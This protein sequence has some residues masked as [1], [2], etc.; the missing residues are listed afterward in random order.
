M[1]QT[2]DISNFSEL[3]TLERLHYEVQTRQNILNFMSINDMLDTD[4]YKKFFEEQIVYVKIYEDFKLD[5]YNWL[6]KEKIIDYNFTGTWN[7][8]FKMKVVELND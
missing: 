1:R 2:F 7:I 6:I 3:N 4:N 8:N 5:F